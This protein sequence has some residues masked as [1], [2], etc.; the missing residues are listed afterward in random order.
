MDLEVTRRLLPLLQAESLKVSESGFESAEQL[1]RFPEV[2]A[3]LIGETLV[4]TH[5]PA[6]C[7][8]RLRGQRESNWSGN[9]V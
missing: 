8:K 1:A 7:L 3:F 2:D 4:R 6:A 5:E 9:E